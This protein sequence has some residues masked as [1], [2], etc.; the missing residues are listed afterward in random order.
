MDATPEAQVPIRLALD[1]ELTGIGELGL[2]T[3][4]RGNPGKQ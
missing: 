1:I 2:I 3:I 4:R